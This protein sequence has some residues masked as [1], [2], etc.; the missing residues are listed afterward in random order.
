MRDKINP[1]DFAHNPGIAAVPP[2]SGLGDPWLSR[3][4]P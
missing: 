2:P 1:A 4:Q 3:C